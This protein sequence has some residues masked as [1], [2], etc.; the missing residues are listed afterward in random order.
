MKIIEITIADQV[1][2]AGAPSPSSRDLINHVPRISMTAKIEDDEDVEE[3]TKALRTRVHAELC[4]HVQVIKD[5]AE[6]T[7]RIMR[8]QREAENKL[9]EQ[10]WSVRDR[11]NREL[12]NQLA[13]GSR[14]DLSMLPIPL[15]DSEKITDYLIRETSNSK[16]G[17]KK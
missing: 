5:H 9:N 3:A 11:V 7:D 12:F 6:L 15:V 4:N 16:E 2:V 13:R 14:P 10:T 17:E 1:K 8:Q